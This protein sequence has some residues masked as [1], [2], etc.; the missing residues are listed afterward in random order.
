VPGKWI[1]SLSQSLYQCFCVTELHK[2]WFGMIIW[3]GCNISH[4]YRNV[5]Y[6]FALWSTQIES[7]LSLF[8]S[9]QMSF[10]HFFLGSVGIIP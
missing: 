6:I 7:C 3:E 8:L 2:L 4:K 10:L 9:F 5:W 1:N